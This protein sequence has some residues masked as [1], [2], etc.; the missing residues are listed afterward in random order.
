MNNILHFALLK[1]YRLPDQVQVTLA[2]SLVVT[3]GSTVVCEHTCVDEHASLTKP[4]VEM[5]K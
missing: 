3:D 1:I 2:V 5:C 4:K